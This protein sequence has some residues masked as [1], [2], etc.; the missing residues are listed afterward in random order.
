MRSAAVSASGARRAWQP[1]LFAVAAAVA[2]FVAMFAVAKAGRQTHREPPPARVAPAPPVGPLPSS[3]A[4]PGLR[5]D[6]R[7]P[8][9]PPAPLP[10]PSPGPRGRRGGPAPPAAPAPGAG[11]GGRAG[12]AAGPAGRAGARPRSDPGP[13]GGASSATATLLQLPVSLFASYD[14]RETVDAGV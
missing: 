4:L 3:R 6:R 10:G 11:P 5:R 8:S 14:D 13:P 2:A 9:P 1:L 7:A 12:G